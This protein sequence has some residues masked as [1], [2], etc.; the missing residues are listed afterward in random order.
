MGSGETICFLKAEL[1]SLDFHCQLTI[2]K[3]PGSRLGATTADL[4]MC[5]DFLKKKPLLLS[6]MRLYRGLFVL[7]NVNK[8]V[9]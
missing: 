2:K 7:I 9:L 1:L 4:V 6:V 3:S 5:Y 8:C